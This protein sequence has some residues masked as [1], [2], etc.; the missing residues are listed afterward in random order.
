MSLSAD[1]SD[2]IREGYW[3]KPCIKCGN[4]AH[5]LM[6]CRGGAIALVGSVWRTIPGNQVRLAEQLHVRLRQ[7]ALKEREKKKKGKGYESES[8]APV[9][10]DA[11]INKDP[12]IPL[13][14]LSI[15]TGVVPTADRNVSTSPLHNVRT[16]VLLQPVETTLPNPAAAPSSKQITSGEPSKAR[17]QIAKIGNAKYPQGKEFSKSTSQVLTNH[18]EVSW[19]AD[20]KFYVYEIVD[21]PAGSKRKTK[22]IINIAIQAWDFLNTNRSH[23]AT[24]HLQTIVAWKNLHDSIQCPRASND[25]TNLTWVPSPVA[26]R[27]RAIDL[28]FRFVGEMYFE[29]MNDFVNPA[30]TPDDST[31]PNFN[32]EP[33]VAHFNTMI[34]NSLTNDVHQASSHKF[35]IKNGYEPLG[36]S[37][38]L[39]IMRGY[40]YTIKP[41]MEKVLL[42]VNVITS[43]FHCPITVAKFL[44]DRTFP[45]NAREKRLKRLRVYVVPDRKPVSD[46]AEQERVDNINLDQNRIKPSK[47][48]ASRLAIE[49]KRSCTST[50]GWR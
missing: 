43:A 34:S 46:K 2:A 32:F 15:T 6:N 40:D 16:Q 26:Y 42:N 3:T 39:C 19:K 20:T 1:I 31:L 9:T 44:E 33:L 36:N 10:Q 45:E 4:D 41:A 22:S 30:R 38:A 25:P 5:A 47:T 27:D 23:F 7:E 12:I 35:F 21:V 13:A 18:F 8:T 24:D 29:C 17:N 14:A 49:A 11:P 50:S 28:K 37:A 48:S